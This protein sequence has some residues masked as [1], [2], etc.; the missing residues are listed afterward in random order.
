MEGVGW[1]MSSGRILTAAPLLPPR[2]CVCPV[3]LIHPGRRVE[4]KGEAKGE[5]EEPP[6]DCLAGKWMALVHFF[7]V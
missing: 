3:E 7:G 1:Q 5:G 6:P 4:A 2:E